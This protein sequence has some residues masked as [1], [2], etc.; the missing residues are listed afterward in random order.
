VLDLDAL[1]ASL[2]PGENQAG[3]IAVQYEGNSGAMIVSGGLA[4]YGEGYSANMPFC[5]HDMSS[6]KSAQYT[7]ASVGVMGGDHAQGEAVC[8]CVH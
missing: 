7:F 6:S 2:P 3:G 4:N 5:S 1:T 8:I